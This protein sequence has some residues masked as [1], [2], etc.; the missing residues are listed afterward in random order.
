MCCRPCRQTITCDGY[1]SSPPILDDHTA[2]ER[3]QHLHRTWPSSALSSC[4][5]HSSFSSSS[6][7]QPEVSES[8]GAYSMRNEFLLTS[9]R[10]SS[11]N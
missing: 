2:T 5:F 3:R 10:S 1:G 6:A 7:S 11:C 9:N 4:P 8:V